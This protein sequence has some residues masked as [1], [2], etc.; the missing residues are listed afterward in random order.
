[1]IDQYILSL[2]H[3]YLSLCAEMQDPNHDADARREL[4]SQRT[5]CHDELIRILGDEY[6]RPFDMKKHCRA[7]LNTP[8]T[9]GRG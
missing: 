6:A 8:P 9:A 2:A 1:M 7:L 5:I 4:S 3:E